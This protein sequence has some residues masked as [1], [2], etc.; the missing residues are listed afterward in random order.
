MLG[1]AS[2]EVYGGVQPYFYVWSTGAN[3]AEVE[4]LPSGTYTVVVSDVVGNNK[5]LT[6]EI[7]GQIPVYDNNGNLICESP[8]PP[9]LDPTGDIGN[10][11]VHAN[12]TVTSDGNIPAGGDVQFKAGETI[13][14]EGGFEIQPNAKFSA[15]IDDC[16]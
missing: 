14:L 12:Q 7:N 11:T 16:Q 4:N 13:I 9:L 5:S 2:V 6:V 3:T 1:R 8:C 15:E 10:S